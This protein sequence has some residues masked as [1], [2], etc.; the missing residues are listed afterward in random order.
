MIE[1]RVAL[2]ILGGCL[3]VV[4]EWAAPNSKIQLKMRLIS[5]SAVIALEP[6]KR[7]KGTGKETDIAIRL[8]ISMMMYVLAT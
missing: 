5:M 8:T 7:W 6:W 1:C 4:V 2:F 3:P